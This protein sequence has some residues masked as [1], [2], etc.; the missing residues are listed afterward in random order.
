MTVCTCGH[1]LIRHNDPPNETFC[2]DCLCV[3]FL[4]SCEEP[5]DDCSQ[6]V[7]AW[8]RLL[9]GAYPETLVF[10]SYL[11]ARWAGAMGWAD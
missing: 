4:S 5:F 9:F 6:D 11:Y 2:L 8:T 7:N 3:V 10:Y 1:T